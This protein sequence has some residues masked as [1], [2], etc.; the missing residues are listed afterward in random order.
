LNAKGS[1]ITA[2]LDQAVGFADAQIRLARKS[3]DLLLFQHDSSENDALQIL[4]ELRLRNQTIPCLFLTEHADEATIA[5]IAQA[6]ACG[7]SRTSS[8]MTGTS[9]IAAV[10]RQPSSRPRRWTRSGNWRVVWP[11]ISTISSW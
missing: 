10:W 2:S 5:K 8:P 11:T 1:L 7:R 4:R 3:Y 6:G 9:V